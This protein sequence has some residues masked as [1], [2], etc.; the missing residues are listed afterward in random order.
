[1]SWINQLLRNSTNG[2]SVDERVANANSALERGQ[3]AFRPYDDPNVR[4]NAAIGAAIDDSGIRD[5]LDSFRDSIPEVVHNLVDG[6]SKTTS[7]SSGAT[8][9]PNRK[10]TNSGKTID[11]LNADLAKHYGMDASAAYGEALQNTAYQRAVADLKA[12]GLNPVLAVSGL[13]P[14]GSYV[15]GNTLARASGSGS[16]GAV[17]SASGK[18][19]MSSNLY[20]ALGAAA[21]IVGAVVGFKTGT[22]GFKWLNA[23]TVSQLSKNLAQAAVQGYGSLTGSR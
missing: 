20:N 4:V 22:G 6:F 17:S 8:Y 15:S 12:A 9:S 2:L 7:A 14:A 11:Y 19:A 13:N 10:A 21:S 3:N 5:R 23:A 18:Y 1:M 16:S